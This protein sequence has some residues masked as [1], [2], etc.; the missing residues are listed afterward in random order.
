MTVASEENKSGPYI[1]NGA[2]TVFDYEFRI[3]NEAHIRVIRAQAGIET[4]LT[5]G[6]DYT[7]S[8]VGD[9]GGGSITATVAPTAA[10][11]ITILRDVPFTQDTD[12]EN[13][14]SYFAETIEAALDLSAMRDQ[15]LRS[16]LTARS[17]SRPRLI[18]QSL[19]RCLA[20]CFCLRIMFRKLIQS[21]ASL[22]PLPQ[23][24][25]SRLM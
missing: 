24:A 16:A 15:Q 22:V 19:R 1:G 13:Q 4:V 6:A 3:L 10:Q 17:P 20:T 11:T 23:L 12:L 14:G 2:T 25:L 5:L 9:A 21:R 7:V 8:G 18:R